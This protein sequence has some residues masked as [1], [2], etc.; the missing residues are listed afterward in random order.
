VGKIDKRK[1]YWVEIQMPTSAFGITHNVNLT[2]FA[3]SKA[4]ILNMFRD[5]AVRRIDVS[6]FH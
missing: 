4:V 2:V 6:P 3:H 1:A 5:Y